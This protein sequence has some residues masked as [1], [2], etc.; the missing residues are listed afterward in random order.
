MEMTEADVLILGGG[1]AGGTLARQ[2]RLAHPELA[3]TVLEQRTAE[4]MQEDDAGLDE[5][6]CEE[7]AS[8]ANRV[9]QLGPHLQKHHIAMGGL[10]FF[11]DSESK[12]LDLDRMSEIGW[13]HPHS[14]PTY[15]L[16]RGA[17]ERHLAELN[18][19]SGVSVRLGVRVLEPDEASGEVITLD[20]V[21]GHQIRTTAGVFR[22]RYLVDA[23]GRSSALARQLHLLEAPV[24]S[25]QGA[26]WARVTGLRPLDSL[27]SE[28]WRRRVPHWGRFA[29]TTHF[30]YRG[31]WLWL[32]P[33]SEDTYSIGMVYDPR[34]VKA[35]P[36]TLQDFESFLRG[37][38]AL[39]Q[40]LGNGARL[41]GFGQQPRFA[42][43]AREQ[44]STDRWYL[45][46][47]AGTAVPPMCSSPSWMTT[48]NNKL[49]GELI[50]ADLLQETVRVERWVRHFH[51]RVR[52][53]YEKL[54]SAF[55]QLALLGSFDAWS[56][57]VASHRRVYFNRIVPDGFEDHRIL[58]AMGAAHE[59]G[60]ACEQNVMRG[61]LSRLLKAA[62]RL[63]LEL[64]SALD[65]HGA[66]HA[67][68]HERFLDSASFEEDAALLAKLY[69]SRNWEVEPQHELR[70]YELLCREAAARLAELEGVAWGEQR[71]LQIFERDWDRGQSLADIVEGM[72][73]PPSSPPTQEEGAAG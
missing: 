34:S 59:A 65:R 73:A 22:G 57:Y 55:S 68:N 69:R 2:L 9:L 23:T 13:S 14:V 29:S 20:P 44:F 64:V 17:F 62:E 71:F 15:A 33:V 21:A 26:C 70:F 61:K 58:L 46:G 54:T 6:T 5:V 37:H 16:D 41:H 3:I 53:R 12:D 42:R 43:F 25:A 45:T 48:E 8:Y 51:V 52:S 4:Q 31:Y 63:C 39:E 11:F 1:T 30:M 72:R 67:N 24:E 56:A 38:R 35:P 10:R 19:H 32:L 36:R 7:F 50:R 47:S 49:I 27:G 18:R 40:L 66:Y 28:A 60:C